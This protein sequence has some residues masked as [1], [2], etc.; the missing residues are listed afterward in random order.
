M[1]PAEAVTG[2][3]MEDL[4]QATVQPAAPEG[5]VSGAWLPIET[6]PYRQDVLVA[7][8][9][10]SGEWVIGEAYLRDT[11]NDYVGAPLWWWAN[12]GPGDYYSDDILSMSGRPLFWRPL[13]EAPGIDDRTESQRQNETDSLRSERDALLAALTEA[14]DVIQLCMPF[15]AAY[16]NDHDSNRAAIIHA[17]ALSALTKADTELAD[18]H[19]RAEADER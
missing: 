14:N 5:A 17:H 12:T 8:M 15:V 16:Q 10:A 7:V 6:A 1:T 3:I 2:K 11:D 13:P 18:V 19:V 9:G 4:V